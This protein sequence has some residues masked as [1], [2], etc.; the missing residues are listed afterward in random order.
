MSRLYLRLPNLPS[1]HHAITSF[2]GFMDLKIGASILTLFAIFNKTAGVYGILAVFQGGTF[3]QVALYLY[4]IA[5]IFIS[6]WGLKG[7]SDQDAQRVLTYAHL[8]T[9]DH[10]ISTFWTLL[11]TI[12]WFYFSPHDGRPTTNQSSHQTGLMD[13][14]ET[15]E[16][17]YRTPEQMAQLH[18]D[19]LTP[20]QRVISAQRIWKEEKHFSA[21]VLG[22]GWMVKIYFAL[23]LYSYALHLRHGTYRTLPLSKAS[24]NSAASR[25]GAGRGEYRYHPVVEEDDEEPESWSDDGEA[26]ATG[27]ASASSHQN[28]N[29][30]GN[31]GSSIPASPQ[32][33]SGGGPR[34][35]IDRLA[36]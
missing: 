26:D 15:I 17:Q 5:T 11:F 32:G 28:K 35:V 13:L 25:S 4:S 23:V 18:H 34:S 14:I 3:S 2:L 6:L 31:G 16:S 1:F 12:N 8:F 33:G 10:M 22:L 20:E 7:I 29:K 36:A 19:Q 27:D 24:A 30:N 21:V 9:L